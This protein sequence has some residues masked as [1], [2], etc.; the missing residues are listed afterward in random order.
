MCFS[1]LS[2][3]PCLP[4]VCQLFRSLLVEL[5]VSLGFIF[6]IF[7]CH[8]LELQPIS[9]NKDML[10]FLVRNVEITP[11]PPLVYQR[12]V[13]L[14]QVTRLLKQVQKRC[15]NDWC[16]LIRNQV[17][18]PENVEEK[19]LL[20]FCLLDTLLLV[21]SVMFPEVAM[22]GLEQPY[23]LNAYSHICVMRHHASALLLPLPGVGL[24]IQLI[25]K[26]VNSSGCTESKMQSDHQSKCATISLTCLESSV[27][28][29]IIQP[30]FGATTFNGH[31]HNIIDQ[32]LLHL[33][34]LL[35]LYRKK[36]QDVDCFK[37]TGC[38]IDYYCKEIFSIGCFL[39]RLEG[40][41]NCWSSPIHNI[42]LVR[43]ATGD[44][45]VIPE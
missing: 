5:V 37:F 17:F 45:R 39:C 33:F 8:G 27:L 44:C 36:W 3:S 21:S 12:Q 4:P 1:L 29:E 38:N 15:G 34:K 25:A 40:E 2:K 6:V 43:Y 11:W 18:Q 20:S 32:L 22:I 35:Q 31:Q 10:T 28:S 14:L 19:K 9:V 26:A 41:I 42:S 16:R 24:Q 30:F 13:T 7:R 23:G